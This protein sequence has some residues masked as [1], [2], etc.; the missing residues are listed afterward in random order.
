MDETAVRIEHTAS[1]LKQHKDEKEVGSL[2]VWSVSSAKPGNGVD[3]LVDGSSETFWQ[4][5]GAQPHLITLQFQHPVQLSRVAIQTDF[6]MDESYTPERITVRVGTRWSD[7]STVRTEDVLEPQGWIIIPLVRG[8]E[9]SSTRSARNPGSP[10]GPRGDGPAYVSGRLLQIGILSNHQ[11]GRD[12]H[13]RQV[14]VFGP[15]KDVT[16]TL[17]QRPG[18]VGWVGAECAMYGTCR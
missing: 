15:R 18:R 9:S 10:R 17:L 14:K 1:H 13:V 5:D 6:R 2:A 12:T 7:I 16:S 8:D 4:S 11:N 3:L